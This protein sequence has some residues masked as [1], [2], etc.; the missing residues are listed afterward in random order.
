VTL[1]SLRRLLPLLSVLAAPASAQ[2]LDRG[3]DLNPALSALRFQSIK[4]VTVV[5]QNNFAQLAGAIEADGHAQVRVALDSIDTKIDL[6]NVRM[7]FLFFETFKFPE[8]LIDVT[9][10]PDMVA[11]LAQERRRIVTVPF[12]L[13]L[14]GVTRVGSAEVAVTLITDNRVSVATTAPI[15]VAAADYGLAENVGKL[16]D[17]GKVTLIPSGSITFD[18]VFDARSAGK[19]SITLV[20]LAPGEAAIETKGAFSREACEVRFQTLSRTGNIYFP[21]G[22][23]R[24]EPDSVP[25]LNGLLDIVRRCPDL[26]VEV[27]GHT[28]SVGGA[29]LNQALSE[30]RATAVADWLTAAGIPPGRLVVRGYGEGRPVAS[31]DT[32]A[33]RAKNRRIEFAAVN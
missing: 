27:A 23:A 4:N 28:D 10:T 33:G 30:A 32:D 1:S 14:H 20:A 17:A 6:R 24:L 29:G 12:A 19:A 3:W 16:E 7:R 25:L 5:E 11:G 21:S 9:I 13:T 18:F 31:N 15:S 22:S 8:A 2:V 26:T